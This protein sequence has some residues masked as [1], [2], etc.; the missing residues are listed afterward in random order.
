VEIDYI[1]LDE[2]VSKIMTKM[3]LSPMQRAHL[4]KLVGTEHYVGIENK[5]ESV[6]G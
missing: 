1:E 5:K 3:T 4:S 6:V 2:F